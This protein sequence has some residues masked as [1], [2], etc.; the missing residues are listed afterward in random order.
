MRKK[1]KKYKRR[2]R[3][4]LN[5]LAYPPPFR[6]HPFLNGYP[7]ALDNFTISPAARAMQPAAFLIPPLHSERLHAAAPAADLARQ[8]LAAP[9]DIDARGV[10]EELVARRP[11]VRLELPGLPRREHRDQAVPVIGLEV[12]RAVHEDESGGLLR[13]GSSCGYAAAASGRRVCERGAA[14]LRRQADGSD[15]L[16]DVGRG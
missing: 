8:V 3:E 12:G 1:K 2:K 15:D 6:P 11:P 14:R 13:R 9:T 7:D 5:S 4:I 10:L 16:K